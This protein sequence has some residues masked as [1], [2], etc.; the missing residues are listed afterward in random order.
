MEKILLVLSS[1]VFILIGCDDTITVN[2][3]DNKTIPSSNVSF[4]N[5]IYPVLQVKCAFTGC[6]AGASPAGGIDLTS[7]TNVTADPNIV[8]PYEPDLS[9]LVWTINGTAG[10]PE[11]PPRYSGLAL[12]ENQKQGIITWIKE[13]AKNN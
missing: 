10:V 2:T 12:T 13:G 7:Y 3:V 11:M 9:R 8:F 6:H 4:A 5:D 1:L